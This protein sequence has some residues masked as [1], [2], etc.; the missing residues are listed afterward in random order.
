MAEAF[1]GEIRCV[2]FNF[3]PQGWA[4]C[5]GQLIPIAQNTA[6]FSLLGTMYGGDGQI[7]FA[8]PDLA[9]RI[10]ICSSN[11]YPPGRRATELAYVSDYQIP[12]SQVPANTIKIVLDNP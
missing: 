3:A 7:T 12:S 4:Q 6:L 10:P 11:G 9:S 2:G 8:L 1:I 5:R